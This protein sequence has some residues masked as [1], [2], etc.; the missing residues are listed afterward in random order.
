MD[1][2]PPDL[3]QSLGGRRAGGNILAVEAA[4]TISKPGSS[5]QDRLESLIYRCEL[6][7]QEVGKATRTAF[8]SLSRAL[9]EVGLEEPAPLT[10]QPIVVQSHDDRNPA[11]YGFVNT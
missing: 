3:F 6:M 8:V 5:A 7:V 9:G 2:P 1:H 10:D 11:A 4:Q